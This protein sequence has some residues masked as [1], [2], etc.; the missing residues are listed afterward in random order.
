[1]VKISDRNFRSGSIEFMGLGIMY[2]KFAERIAQLSMRF[3]LETPTVNV[4]TSGRLL[5]NII[6]F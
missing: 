1:M 6:P 3:V 4:P 2:S 5:F